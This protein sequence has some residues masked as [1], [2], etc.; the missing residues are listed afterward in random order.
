[1]IILLVGAA[2]AGGRVY[3]SQHVHVGVRPALANEGAAL[4]I[5]VT[6]DALP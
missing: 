4:T 6:T 5:Q 3:T 1:M 2:C